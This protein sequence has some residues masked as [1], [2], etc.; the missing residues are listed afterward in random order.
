[1][2][3]S[4]LAEL[5]RSVGMNAPDGPPMPWQS[6]A[7]IWTGLVLIAWAVS[8]PFILHVLRSRR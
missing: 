8:T 1:M 6:I 4:A 3:G 2:D 7:S 5:C